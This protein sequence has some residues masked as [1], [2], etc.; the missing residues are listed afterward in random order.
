MPKLTIDKNSCKGCGLCVTF[1]PKGILKLSENEL[2]D[3][4]YNPVEIIDMD[5]CTACAACAPVAGSSS[6]VPPPA[7]T[8]APS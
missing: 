2:N 7:P 5:A 3:K 6:P 4:G 1:C 8:P